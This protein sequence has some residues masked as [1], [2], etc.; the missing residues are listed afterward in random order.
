MRVQGERVG[1]ALAGGGSA[2]SGLDA[3][4]APST[5]GSQATSGRAA[6]SPSTPAVRSA[7]RR[8]AEPASHEARDR[9]L[10]PP[11]RRRWQGVPHALHRAHRTATTG[12][13]RISVHQAAQHRVDEE[14]ARVHL[15]HAVTHQHEHRR[16]RAGAFEVLAERA[17]EP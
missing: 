2:I 13:G 6:S 7:S 9:R 4:G 17:V 1:A 11:A 16:V 5:V 8:A 12:A 14:D 3:T 10:E 15:T